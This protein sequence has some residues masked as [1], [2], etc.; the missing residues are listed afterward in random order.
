MPAIPIEPEHFPWKDYRR[1]TYPLGLRLGDWSLLT[2]ESASEYDAVEKRVVVRGGMSEQATMAYRQIGAVLEADGFDY[3]DVVHIVDFVKPATLPVYA[4]AVKVRKALMGDANPAVNTICV[5]R[6]L[7]NDSLIE[8]EVSASKESANPAPR[9]ARGRSGGASSTSHHGIVHLS[10]VLALDGQGSVTHKDSM[11]DQIHA[12]YGL[13]GDALAAS[14]LGWENVVK[15]IT[16]VPV[17]AKD[18]YDRFAE[19][20]ATY[21]ADGPRP[22][23]S[24]YF[25]ERLT[26]DDA[27]IQLD[28]TA[29]TQ[30][31]EA[32]DP[33]WAE[34]FSG[35]RYTPAIRVGD[36]VFFSAQRAI[37]S[38]TGAV[39]SPGDIKA[40]SAYVYQTRMGELLRKLGVDASA[41][42]QTTEWLTPRGHERYRE[43]AEVRRQFLLPPYPASAGMIVS[44]LGPDDSVFAVD[45]LGYL[46]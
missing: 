1:Y 37:D 43:T 24:V 4:E 16:T 2:G 34:E 20:S 13:V 12:A 10:S 15:I 44:S 28:V 19:E 41:I 35:V 45:A 46:G 33:G 31:M 38:G 9:Q 39:V 11:R 32:V 36:I 30:D 40:Q 21:L 3:H 5:N 23:G 42:V 7:R 8:I 18:E 6:L 25:V 22:C 17:R 29:T 14:G 26:E 27:L